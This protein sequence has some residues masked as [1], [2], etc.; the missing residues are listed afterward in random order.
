MTKLEQRV[1]DFA[2]IKKGT[3]E[4]YHSLFIVQHDLSVAVWTGNTKRPSYYY[5]F[6]TEQQRQNFI[7]EKKQSADYQHEQTERWRDK[8]A[9]ETNNIVQDAVLYDCWG[10]EQTNI[11]FYIVRKRTDKTVWLQKLQSTVKET[12]FMSGLT[13][14][15]VD[16]VEGDELLMRKIG[17]YG[18]AIA[19]HRAS[20]SVY[21][22]VAKSCSW[23][24]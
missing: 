5:K 19:S 1:N 24:A 14:P 12:G 9:K 13:E 17:K 6:S 10:Y 2:N 23:Y 3:V 7:N 21:D 22:G 8:I 18:V 11:D 15:I 4:K 16:Q 20:L